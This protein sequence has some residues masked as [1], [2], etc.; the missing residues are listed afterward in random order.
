MG[1]PEKSMMSRDMHKKTGEN[2]MRRNRAKRGSNIL[3]I[4]G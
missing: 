2:K 1:L 3:F 4:Y